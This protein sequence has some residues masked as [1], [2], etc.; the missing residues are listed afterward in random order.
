MTVRRVLTI[1]A[2]AVA[3]AVG[4]CA[5][6]TPAQVSSTQEQARVAFLKGHDGFSDRDLARLCP[7][8]YPAGFLTDVKRY[9]EAKVVKGHVSPKVTAAD[10]AQAVAAGC[11][12]RS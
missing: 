12:V 3:L 2:G 9:P 4:G 8:L 5:Y 6:G 10:R 7:A 11:G 1:V